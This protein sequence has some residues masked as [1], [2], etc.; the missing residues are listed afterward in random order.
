[1]RSSRKQEESAA[2]DL[3]GRRS[4]GSG[5][6]WVY[7][8]DAAGK[9]IR[10]WIFGGFMVE[11]K[12]TKHLSRSVGVKE[13][14]KAQNDAWSLGAIPVMDVLFQNTRPMMRL[15]ILEW[16]VFTDLVNEVLDGEDQSS[17]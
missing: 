2:R 12:G 14:A 10:G 8:G 1:M 5:S 13:F 4:P 15:A 6:V 3:G 7:R 11:S 9:R 17:G 16:E